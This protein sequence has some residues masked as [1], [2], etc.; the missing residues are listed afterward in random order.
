M[1]PVATW[2]ENQWKRKD[3]NPTLN[4]SSPNAI[5]FWLL[6]LVCGTTSHLT[7]KIETLGS[8]PKLNSFN[9]SLASLRISS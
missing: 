3:E 2:R 9:P 8:L 6:Y 4:L 5:L 1:D 7:V